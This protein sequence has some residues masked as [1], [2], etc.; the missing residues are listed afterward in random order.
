MV[1]PAFENL[2]IDLWVHQGTLGIA[3]PSLCVF[4]DDPTVGTQLLEAL[5][6]LQ[7]DTCPAQRV[8]TFRA[9]SRKSALLKLKLKLV[10]DHEDLKVM[11]VGRDR[12]TAV[13][14]MTAEGLSLLT[15]AFARWLAGG[16]DFGVSP[17]S[18]SLKRKEFGRLDRES[19]ELW[20][21]GPWY[22][23]P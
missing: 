15:D 10:A 18:S 17:T 1:K 22:A 20:F 2:Q 4:H 6:E 14:E 12:D 16:E 11:H 23:G 19:G 3:Q 21:W 9:S 13:I 5:K 7:D 8:L